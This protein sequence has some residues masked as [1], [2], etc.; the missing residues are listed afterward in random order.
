MVRL[1]SVV[2][3][4]GGS[5]VTDDAN[6]S[7]QNA[8]IRSHFVSQFS[9]FA[10]GVVVSL[11]GLYFG[12]NSGLAVGIGN[13]TIL[14]AIVGLAYLFY[15]CSLSELTSTLP[16][17]GGS[18]GLARCSVGFYWGYMAGCCAIVYYLFMTLV[19]N[20]NIV[21]LLITRYPG[22]EVYGL[23]M[24]LLLFVAQL[25][26][27]V[28]QPLFWRTTTLIAALSIM[29]LLIYCIDALTVTDFPK[30][31]LF[32]SEYNR[33]TMMNAT[34]VSWAPLGGHSL[35]AGLFVGSAKEVAR[36]IPY[37]M[38]FFIG[39]EVVNLLCDEVKRPRS[40]VPVA[41]VSV[42][43]LL[44]VF[45]FWVCLA[46]VAAPPGIAHGAKTGFP[47]E[48]GMFTCQLFIAQLWWRMT[49]FSCDV[50]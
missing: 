33:N 47:L 35:Y 40:E 48:H 1:R 20:G 43:V 18:Y 41:Q 17:P 30:Y 26:F 31:A 9:L 42:A 12:W 32:T 5:P 6:S 8:A 38:Y 21:N 44:I 3:V 37:S 45:A 19:S 16:F 29:M 11:D 14:T 36:Q 24:F 39:N 46:T 7:H 15:Y 28:V 25:A 23:I 49:E 2:P 10:L 13:F 27:C 22:L 4:D 34:E 50:C